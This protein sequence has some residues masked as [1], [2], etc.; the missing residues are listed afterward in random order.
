MPGPIGAHPRPL[1]DEHECKGEH[2]KSRA[3]SK[4][5]EQHHSRL[6]VHI[7]LGCKVRTNVSKEREDEEW[8]G[9]DNELEEAPAEPADVA[10]CVR[11]SILGLL[12]GAGGVYSLPGGQGNTGRAEMNRVGSHDLIPRHDG[13][14]A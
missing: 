5:N 1:D 8:K 13:L 4:K 7:V 12:A 9:Q 10:W 6:T 2:P 14:D 3:Y 11:Q